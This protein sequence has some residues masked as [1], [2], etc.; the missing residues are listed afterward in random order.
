MNVEDLF[1]KFESDLS[2]NEFCTKSFDKKFKCVEHNSECS[3]SI[4][5]NNVSSDYEEM[6]S[7][8]S[9]SY[10]FNKQEKDGNMTKNES[11][12]NM[13]ERVEIYNNNMD[14]SSCDE[15]ENETFIV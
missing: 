5:A 1:K 4:D 3:E 9:E 12:N 2:S 10:D 7:R 15:N 11:C 14:N 13:C 6:D 8:S